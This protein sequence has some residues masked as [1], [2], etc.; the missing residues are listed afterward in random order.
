VAQPDDA[1]RAGV[2]S[3]QVADLVDG[4][5]ASVADGVDGDDGVLA[6]QPAGEIVGSA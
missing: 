5:Y 3:G 4:D 6:T 1:A 2:S